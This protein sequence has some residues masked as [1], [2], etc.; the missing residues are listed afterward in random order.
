MHYDSPFSSS[1][2]PFMMELAFS[3]PKEEA[4]IPFEVTLGSTEVRE[5]E[6]GT[7]GLL[8]SDS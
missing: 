7:P 8:G 1:V 3:S 6:F 2:L 4:A 5:A